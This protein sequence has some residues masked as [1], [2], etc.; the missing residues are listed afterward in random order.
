MQLYT[1]FCTYSISMLWQSVRRTIPNPS[2]L[3]K[4]F[5]GFCFKRSTEPSEVLPPLSSD[6]CMIRDCLRKSKVN[7]RITA[8]DPFI[9]DQLF[10]CSMSPSNG[11]ATNT[12]CSVKHAS[13]LWKMQGNEFKSIYTETITSGIRSALRFLPPNWNFFLVQPFL[14]GSRSAFGK[15]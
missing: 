1:Q 13:F 11:S 7:R 5:C 2:S 10:F 8:I 3:I 9:H 14:W 12:K 6:V 15:S 4:A